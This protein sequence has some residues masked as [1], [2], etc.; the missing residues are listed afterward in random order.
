MTLVRTFG[1]YV[2]SRRTIPAISR[3]QARPAGGNRTNA[4]EDTGYTHRSATGSNVDENC[5][6]EERDKPTEADA[7]QISSYE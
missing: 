4:N 5:N 2:L 1:G 3:Q 6:P 7:D